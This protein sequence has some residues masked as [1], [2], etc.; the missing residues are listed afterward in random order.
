M[1]VAPRKPPAVTTEQAHS[2]VHLL[3]QAKALREV[4]ASSW[5]YE[6][7]NLRAFCCRYVID[8]V[9]H[10]ALVMQTRG[11]YNYQAGFVTYGRR[12]QTNSLGLTTQGIC[13]WLGLDRVPEVVEW[14]IEL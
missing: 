3:E 12:E 10:H 5:E 1:S 8:G 13:V 2:A 4:L 9:L 7:G 11:A 14:S 6:E